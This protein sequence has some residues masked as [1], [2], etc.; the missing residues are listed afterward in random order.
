MCPSFINFDKKIFELE[1][2]RRRDRRTYVRMY[3]R[4]YVHMD[5]RTGVTLN[6]PAIIM[7]GA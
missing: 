2:G 5:G 4:T 1:S 6:A 7:A 3:V